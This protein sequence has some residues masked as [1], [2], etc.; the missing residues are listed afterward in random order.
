MDRRTRQAG[1]AEA[2]GVE[3]PAEYLCEANC[4]P[5]LNGLLELHAHYKSM[6]SSATAVSLGT[7]VSATRFCYSD[8]EG[9]SFFYLVTVCVSPGPERSHDTRTLTTTSRGRHT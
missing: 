9:A 3:R 1:T 5:P 6:P 7:G 2:L 4:R 8:Q